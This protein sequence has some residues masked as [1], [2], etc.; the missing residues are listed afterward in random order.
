MKLSSCFWGI[1]CEM[2]GNEIF[3]PLKTLKC[4]ETTFVNKVMQISLSK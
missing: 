4:Q 1:K 2:K 3:Q